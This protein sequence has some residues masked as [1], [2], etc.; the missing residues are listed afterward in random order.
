VVSKKIAK[1]WL[2]RLRAAESFASQCRKFEFNP[3]VDGE[4]V[5]MLLV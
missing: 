1:V 2:C 5:N 3:L 4:P